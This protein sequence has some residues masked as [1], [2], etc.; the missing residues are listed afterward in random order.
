MNT[1][2]SARGVNAA[3]IGKK[4]GFLNASSDENAAIADT[5]A[6]CAVIATQHH[7]HA[8]QVLAALEA[9]K[10][11][12]CEK[13]LCISHAELNKIEKVAKSRPDQI[14]MVGFNRRFSPFIIKAKNLI[15]AESAPK[16]IIITVN[17]GFIPK[18]HWTQDKNI[19]GGR[20]IGEACHFI[21]LSTFLTGE[22]IISTHVSFAG[23]IDGL[24][25]ISD[26]ASITLNFSGGSVSTIHYLGNGHRSFPKERIEIF[27]SG[28]IVSIINFRRMFGFGWS[29]FKK[30]KLWRQNKGQVECV[31]AFVRAVSKGEPAPISFDQVIDVTRKTIQIA[32]Q[33]YEKD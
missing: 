20:I 8:E 11:I 10:H 21:D 9:G 30:L 28:K 23:S 33:S 14:L 13:P 17:A 1:C 29:H 3:Y 25:K 5:E 22:Q 6:N 19:G 26:Q 4:Y 32:E 27:V 7:L 12:F 2:V 24:G 18:D 15:C 31:E 16:N